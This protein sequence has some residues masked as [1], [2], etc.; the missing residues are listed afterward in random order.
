M[1]IDLEKAAVSLVVV[2]L[3]VYATLFVYS[4]P[5]MERIFL[6]FIDAPDTAASIKV[7]SEYGL[8]CKVPFFMDGEYSMLGNFPPLFP[9]LGA[10]INAVVG[11][12]VTSAAVLNVLVSVAMFYLLYAHAFK[13][14]EINQRLLFSGF[15]LMS[16]FSTI[17]FP[18][19]VRM[20]SHL[21][22]LFGMS[23]FVFKP[24]GLPLLAIT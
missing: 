21:A 11:S 2:L 6:S 17:Y 8:T 10:L 15:F 16:M 14:L 4:L 18:F 3:L 24:K 1:K 13:H 9:L 23:M 5:Q 19:G 7:V 22:A 12:P 20:R